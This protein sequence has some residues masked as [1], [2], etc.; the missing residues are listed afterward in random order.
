MV[1]NYV[2]KVLLICNGLPYK[3]FTLV[4]SEEINYYASLLLLIIVLV[5]MFNLY[6]VPTWHISSMRIIDFII[7]S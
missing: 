1:G 4:F 3:Y 5:H 7:M 2:C 6:T